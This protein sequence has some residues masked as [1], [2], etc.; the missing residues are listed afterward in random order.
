MRRTAVLLALSL[1]A[2][3]G[4]REAA[5]TP[6]AEADVDTADR[7]HLDAMSRE[8]AGET[9]TSNAA[10]MEP[11]QEV[12]AEEVVYGTVGGREATGYLARPASAAPDEAL[13][14][15]VLVHEWWG[16]NDNMRMTARRLAGEGYR[17]LAVDLY[18]GEV[19]EDAQGARALMQGV[20]ENPDRGAAHLAAAADFLRTERDA[21]AVGIVGWCFGGGW[22]LQG[23]L[24]FPGRY[25]AAVMYYG[26]VVTDRGELARLDDPLLGLFGAEDRGI[27]VAEV[28][29]MEGALDELGKDVEVVVYEGA[30]HAFANPS[31]D[32]YRPE[33]AADAWRR[34][35][36]F[37][38]EHLK[39]GGET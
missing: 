24:R 27:P 38:G 6:N 1:L 18:G 22:A 14:A 25:D 3:C 36:A 32:A 2:A 4:P 15:V 17:A 30:G 26:R 34:T 31:G 7:A 33:P 9:P 10:W 13:P 19:A 16:L 8:H 21:P 23:A 29:E 28:R 39:D 12:T 37:F 35:L 20:T 5:E 11:A